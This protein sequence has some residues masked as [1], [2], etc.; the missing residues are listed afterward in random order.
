MKS[1]LI[2]CLALVLSGG[3]FGCS[4]D[5]PPD[6]RNV[7]DGFQLE[8][9][10]SVVEKA[11]SNAT[12]PVEG[13]M[14]ND[15]SWWNALD[16]LDRHYW[17]WA[18]NTSIP[19]RLSK[20]VLAIYPFLTNGYANPQPKDIA[21]WFYPIII[22]GKTHDPAMA[23][24]LR[25]YLKDKDLADDPGGLNNGKTTMRICDEAEMAIDSLLDLKVGVWN[26][27]MFLVGYDVF[28]N[29]TTVTHWQSHM[30]GSAADDKPWTGFDPVWK[31][32]DKRIAKLE[33]RLD[34][35]GFTNTP[36][37]YSNGVVHI[38]PAIITNAPNIDPATG[39]PT[40][41]FFDPATG[42][43]SS[44]PVDPATGLPVALP[45]KSDKQP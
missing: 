18:T 45:Q 19:P 14:T 23:S 32:W 27:D 20:V 9:E 16:E 34:A 12:L 6:D 22:L 24:V 42:L 37:W 41:Y 35:M 44:E 1:K 31:V 25:P 7:N 3:L 15:D 4:T 30:M 26:A 11:A 2:L 33:K 28:T 21:G 39:L 17:L 43:R 13:L 10:V 29:G 8:T 38:S 40:D 5:S 36:A